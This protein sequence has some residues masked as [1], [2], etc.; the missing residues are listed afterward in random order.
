MFNTD[1]QQVT[2]TDF[3]IARITSETRTQTGEIIGSP[4]F[5]SPEQVKGQKVGEASDIFSLGVTFFQ[6][7]TGE[8]PFKGDNIA[9]L[10]YQI[11][12]GK[13][14]NIRDL[15][16]QLPSSA[17]RIINKALHKEPQNRF[18]DAGEMARILRNALQ[19][20]F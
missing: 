15:R 8:L 4:L 18:S 5:M 9:G 2:V 7:L 3:G 10:S 11:I 1:S 14:K 6:L 19:K 17:V 20:D 12:H 16:S 13:H